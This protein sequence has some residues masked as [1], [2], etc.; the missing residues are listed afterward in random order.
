[1]NRIIGLIFYEA[2]LDAERYI[3][4]KLNPFFVNLA[5]AKEMFGYFMQD[6][7]SPHTANEIVRTLRGMFGKLNGEEE[8]L[9]RVCGPLGPQSK[10]L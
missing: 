6:S 1:V 9:S 3:N 4:E 2:T 5:P 10:P 7:T 8:L